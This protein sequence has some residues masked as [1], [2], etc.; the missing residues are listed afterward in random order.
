[1]G[2]KHSHKCFVEEPSLYVPVEPCDELARVHKKIQQSEEWDPV[3]QALH[4]AEAERQLG[5]PSSSKASRAQL[6]A[7]AKAK[8]AKAKGTNFVGDPKWNL[9]T[10]RCVELFM[11]AEQRMRRSLRDQFGNARSEEVIGVIFKDTHE[12]DAHPKQAHAT[13]IHAKGKSIPR[14]RAVVKKKPS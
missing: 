10:R 7:A 9:Q 13:L 8:V 12:Q 14:P 5:L 6:L 3:G 1:M 11:S 2:R 4:I